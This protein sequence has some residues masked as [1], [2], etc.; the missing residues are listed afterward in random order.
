MDVLRETGVGKQ[1]FTDKRILKDVHW[2]PGGQRQIGVSWSG[3][4]DGHLGGDRILCTIYLQWRMYIRRYV[5]VGKHE[6]N[7]IQM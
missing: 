6:Y 1:I 4:D 3:I 5:Y 2:W 7:N